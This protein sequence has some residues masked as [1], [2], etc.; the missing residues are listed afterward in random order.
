M[1]PTIV[2]VHG[3]F[4]E[5][6]SWSG[7]IQRLHADGYPGVAAPNPLRSLSGDAAVVSS[8]LA[9]TDEPVVLVGHSYG[10][11]ACR[12]R[13]D[14]VGDQHGAVAEDLGEFAVRDGNHVAV[15]NVSG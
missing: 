7:V 11:G 10:G 8:I 4:A 15:F 6:A 14:E 2:L 3:A 13:H 12:Q 9:T 5:S 1:N